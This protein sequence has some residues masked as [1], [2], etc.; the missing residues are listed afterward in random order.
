MEKERERKWV[1]DIE[2]LTTSS[3]EYVS[4]T[5]MLILPN[6]TPSARQGVGLCMCS[7]L[8]TPVE[9][10][11]VKSPYV[12]IYVRVGLYRQIGR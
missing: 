11:A 6:S 8:C 7:L 10:N 3:P 9:E 2:T 12:L 4:D 1:Q 5:C